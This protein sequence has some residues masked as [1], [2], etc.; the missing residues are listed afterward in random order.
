MQCS[1]TAQSA[2]VARHASP[3]P[4]VPSPRQQPPPGHPSQRVRRGTP[5]L[6]APARETCAVHTD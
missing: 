4:H 1:P 5:M 2:V 3:I 6:A